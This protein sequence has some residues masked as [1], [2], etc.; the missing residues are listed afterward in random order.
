[1]EFPSIPPPPRHYYSPSS[2]SILDP[3]CSQQQAT[4]HRVSLQFQYSTLV[5]ILSDFSRFSLS[6][7]RNQSCLVTDGRWEELAASVFFFFF[8]FLFFGKRSGSRRRNFKKFLSR[9][10]LGNACVSLSLCL[11][12]SLVRYFELLSREKR[13]ETRRRVLNLVRTTRR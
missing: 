8:F 4:E 2:L 6:N 7:G 9:R 1:M 11:S 5:P 13:V 12:L 3:A 10:K